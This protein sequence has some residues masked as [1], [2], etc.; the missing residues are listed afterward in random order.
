MRFREIRPRYRYTEYVRVFTCWLIRRCSIVLG[1]PCGGYGTIGG[2]RGRLVDV[3]I[4]ILLWSAGYLCLRHPPSARPLQ[5]AYDS[6]AW[7]ELPVPL[8]DF[9]RRAPICCRSY[10]VESF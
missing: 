7:L 2:L 1:R 6:M 9:R 8:V 10:G 3:I 4:G 5:G